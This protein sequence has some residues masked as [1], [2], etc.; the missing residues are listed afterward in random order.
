MAVGGG[1]GDAG[2]WGSRGWPGRGCVPIPLHPCG[3]GLRGG[4]PRGEPARPW[5]ACGVDQHGA[6]R[7]APLHLR[8]RGRCNRVAQSGRRAWSVYHERGLCGAGGRAGTGGVCGQCADP[9][10]AE[11]GRHSLRRAVQQAAR[12]LR[13][14][15]RGEPGCGWRG[16][17]QGC[18]LPGAVPG[19][20]RRATRGQS[21]DLLL[22]RGERPAEPG[23]GVRSL[24][25]RPGPGGI[26]VGTGIRRWGASR[27]RGPRIGTIPSCTRISGIPCSGGGWSA[28]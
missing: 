23:R 6:R 4:L 22:L 11:G 21:G 3:R 8:G 13:W 2:L 5:R 27:S 20:C 19:G 12:R 14:L 24:G 16:R 15:A 17:G 26:P 18:G 1:V 25:F 28:M 9:A 10:A 7:R